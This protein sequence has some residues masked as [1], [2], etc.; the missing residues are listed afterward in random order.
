[1]ST[2]VRSASAHGVTLH[3]A[4]RA[5]FGYD[6]AVLGVALALRWDFPA[7]IAHAIASHAAP[8]SPSSTQP[9]GYV[10]RACVLARSWGGADGL[11]QTQASVTPI[12]WLSA[13]LATTLADAGGIEDLA[14]R[15]DAFLAM[16]MPEAG[17][18]ARVA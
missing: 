4:E 18:I 16:V 3:E 15:L 1:M 17:E 7:P 10:A 8:V 12:E 9:M 6:E 5:I 2:A 11:E 14:Q 13:P